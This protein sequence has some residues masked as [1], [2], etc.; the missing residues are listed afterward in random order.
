[1]IAQVKFKGLFAVAAVLGAAC[2][3]LVAS[4]I[5]A[6]SSRD[7]TIPMR[8]R[9]TDVADA[10]AMLRSLGLRVAV[11]HAT[12]YSSLKPAWVSKMTPAAGARVPV[13]TVVTLTPSN[14]GPIG[15]AA[16]LKSHPHYR[17]PSFIGRTAASAISWANSHHMF[18]S[19]PHV[20]SLPASDARTFFAAYRV[21]AQAPRPGNTIVQGIMIGEGFKPTP[22]T[23][24]V[25][26]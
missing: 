25:R 9:E 22:L 17:V 19:I 23:L 5:G 2:A 13:G 10:F 24:T 21:T 7:V 8:A 15:S 26:P 12:A 11:D 20:P 4:G 1:M 3:L 14:L 18:W 6:A 16:V